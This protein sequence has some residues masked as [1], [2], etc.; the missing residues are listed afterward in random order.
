MTKRGRDFKKNAMP[1]WKGSPLSGRLEVNIEAYPSSKR[2]FDLDN[3][4][5]P[6]LDL[7]TDNGVWLDDSQVDILR[8]RRRDIEKPGYVRV[9]IT[10]I[11]Y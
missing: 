5:K 1:A 3:I 4:L 8:I 11:D 7:L 2:R 9:L 6:I 10:E